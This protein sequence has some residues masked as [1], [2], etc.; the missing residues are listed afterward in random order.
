MTRVSEIMTGPPV[1][2]D[3]AT[4]VVDVAKMMEA[5]DL[6]AV[7]VCDDAGRPRGVVT[8]RDLAVDVIAAGR[9]PARTQAGDL[10]LGTKVATVEGGLAPGRCRQDDEGACRPAPSCHVGGKGGGGGQSSRHRPGG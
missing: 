6:G 10:L 8:D 1:V 5:R 2:V 4:S 9:D 3:A 7:I